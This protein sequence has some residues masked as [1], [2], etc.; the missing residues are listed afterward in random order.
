MGKNYEHLSIEEKTMIQLGLEQDC[1]LRAI[2]RR[3]QRSPSTITRELAR[4]DWT[5]PAARP[6]KRGRPPV[7]C[8]Y[9]ATAAHERARRRAAT[10]R[11]PPRLAM[12]GPL[13]PIV[14]DMLRQR[15]SPE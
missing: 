7:G 11:Y 15:Y 10:P 8:G 1:A 2:A 6:R 5:C 13:W 12:E 4:N 9:R 3:M 14:A